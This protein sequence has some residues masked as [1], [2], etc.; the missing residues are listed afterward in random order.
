[1]KLPLQ[2]LND[3]HRK[4]AQLMVRGL[5]L[6]E[7]S[8]LVGLGRITCRSSRNPGCS[9]SMRRT[10]GG[11]IRRRLPT[12]LSARISSRSG[13]G[14]KSCAIGATGGEAGRAGRRLGSESVS[15]R[16]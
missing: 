9:G 10:A 12:A 2:R 16:R 1:M 5:S 13:S 15:D 3:N 11:R 6:V 7:I 8:R 14:S 4:A